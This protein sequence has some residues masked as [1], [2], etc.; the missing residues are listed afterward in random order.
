MASPE[1]AT[2]LFSACIVRF[3][4]KSPGSFSAS[5][6]SASGDPDFSPNQRPRRL[7][8]LCADARR[9]LITGMVDYPR[10]PA[11]LAEQPARTKLSCLLDWWSRQ[12]EKNIPIWP[13]GD[14]TK[15]G[16]PGRSRKSFRQIDLTRNPRSPAIP[17]GISKPS[18]TM[19]D[20]RNRLITATYSEPAVLPHLTCRRVPIPTL[21]T[22]KQSSGRQL[23]RWSAP[24]TERVLLLDSPNQTSCWMAHR[25]PVHRLAIQRTN[26]RH[27]RGRPFLIH[28]FRLLSPP[29]LSAVGADV[30]RLKPSLRDHTQ[31]LRHHRE[32]PRQLPTY[33]PSNCTACSCITIQTN[34]LPCRY[35]ASARP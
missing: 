13:G 32:L 31:H 30:R 4:S 34:S 19:P 25:N 18:R 10:P 15:A 2:N 27:H 7:H 16:S 1:C 23:I 9:W 24:S 33:S 21:T 8:S 20:L 14:I 11:L 6:P 5:V 28:P 35:V 29:A 22:S 26:A 17:I 12:T 3:I